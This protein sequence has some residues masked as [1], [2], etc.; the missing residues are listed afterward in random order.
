[1]EYFSN[2]FFLIAL[3]FGTYFLGK[4]LRR[5]TGWV[6]M[7]P[8]LISI[9]CII[10]FLKITGISYEAYN[11]GGHMIEFWL[12]PAVVALGVPLYMQLSTIKKQLTPIVI[13]ELAG[14]RQSR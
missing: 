7:N 3:T 1:M 11:Q 5:L 9:A 4:L 10:A 13:S 6:V 12:R 14:W 2:D 8:I